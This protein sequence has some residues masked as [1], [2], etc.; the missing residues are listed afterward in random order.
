[1]SYVEICN[2]F[3]EKSSPIQDLSLIFSVDLDVGKT[4]SLYKKIVRWASVKAVNS[5]TPE[6]Y[7]QKTANEILAYLL[8]EL[9]SPLAY[10][11]G[12]LKH[13]ADPWLAPDCQFV[14]KG[15][16][17]ASWSNL[18]FL[19]ELK[20]V[21]VGNKNGIGQAIKA[22]KA[23]LSQQSKRERLIV[24]YSNLREIQF[25]SMGPNP[26]LTSVMELF[27]EYSE[28]TTCY[29]ATNG[30][31][32][33]VRLLQANVHQHDFSLI[34]SVTVDDMDFKVVESQ[35][36]RGAQNIVHRVFHD[37]NDQ[38]ALRIPLNDDAFT[39]VAT[40]NSWKGSICQ[41][42]EALEKQGADFSFLPEFIDIPRLR[43]A[44]A[45]PVGQS[46]KAY[47]Q[48]IDRGSVKE[49]T[50][51]KFGLKWLKGLRG[52]HMAGFCHGD[53]RPMNILVMPTDG[54]RVVFIDWDGCTREGAM[55][56]QYTFA[57]GSDRLISSTENL[58]FT[59]SIRDDLETF[60]YGMYFLA[61]PGI[62]PPWLRPAKNGMS[63]IIKARQKVF[64]NLLEERKQPEMSLEVRRLIKNL[65]DALMTHRK[66]GSDVEL[67]FQSFQ[68]ILS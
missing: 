5:S 59:Q 37:G 57:F 15:T 52:L 23:V 61:L 66:S 58:A 36:G 42:R 38:I 31:V 19:G 56:K 1:M 30:F 12:T 41:V 28:G 68:T 33:L 60:V 11:D 40:V 63:E 46:L 48:R 45:M 55:A 35:I 10:L 22:G 4:N 20:K 21:K 16:S 53:L 9:N 29:E 13:L 2:H 44:I 67:L 50:L 39:S 34:Q 25:A 8:K 51:K 54:E 6:E 14:T 47:C 32:E 7:I 43:S 62:H 17:V 27:E 3:M 64:N 18:V 24:F 65:Y 26:A 49:A